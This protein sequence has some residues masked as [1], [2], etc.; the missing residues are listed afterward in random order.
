MSDG[1]TVYT[2]RVF[3]GDQCDWHTHPWHRLLRVLKCNQG[4]SIEF[5]CGRLQALI[6][7]EVVY[8]PANVSHRLCPGPGNLSLEIIEHVKLEQ[9]AHSET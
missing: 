2:V 3:S 5:E 1:K 9:G 4:W 8:V 7:G 6:G